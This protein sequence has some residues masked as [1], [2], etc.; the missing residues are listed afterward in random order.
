MFIYINIYAK[1][2]TRVCVQGLKLTKTYKKKQINSNINYMSF[3]Y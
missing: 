3:R 1:Q 2:C